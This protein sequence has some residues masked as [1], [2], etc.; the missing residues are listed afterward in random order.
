MPHQ[1]VNHGF[2]FQSSDASTCNVASGKVAER[3][4]EVLGGVP[5]VL[6]L[7][8]QGFTD[9]GVPY[10]TAGASVFTI[11]S[12]C[13][14]DFAIGC[15]SRRTMAQNRSTAKYAASLVRP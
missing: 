9:T 12:Q 14:I 10:P 3:R 5:L 2:H 13:I 1:S 15:H 6:C 4:I 11:V 7:S 8:N